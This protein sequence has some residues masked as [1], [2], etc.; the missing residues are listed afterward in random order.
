M[1]GTYEVGTHKAREKV[2][3]HTIFCD[4]TFFRNENFLFASVLLQTICSVFYHRVFSRWLCYLLEIVRG[5][6]ICAGQV[7]IYLIIIISSICGTIL[8]NYFIQILL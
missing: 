8:P 6:Q 4:I 1:K 3:S 2:K 7:T 5:C